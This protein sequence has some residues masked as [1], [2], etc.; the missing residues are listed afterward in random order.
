MNSVR[1]T[2]SELWKLTPHAFN[3]WR[4]QNDLPELLHVFKEKLPDFVMWLEEFGIEPVF[5][6]PSH[7]GRWLTGDISKKY[8]E[9]SHGGTNRCE[10]VDT[11]GCKE[12]FTL[13][14]S[15]AASVF[16]EFE[17]LPY[18][19]WA[20]NRFAMRDFMCVDSLNRG[21]S[22]T[23]KY[24]QSGKYEVE[25]GRV[26]GTKERIFDCFDL[27]KLGE[28]RV[29]GSLWLD[30]NLDF[31]D[32]DKVVFSGKAFMYNWLEVSLSSCREMVLESTWLGRVCFTECM[33]EKLSV[34]H[35]EIRK[36]NFANSNLPGLVLANSTLHNVTIGGT[37]LSD[38]DI[39][40]TNIIDLTYK[41][42]VDKNNSRE[43]TTIKDVHR[44]L[45]IAFQ[46]HGKILEARYHYY[47][48]RIFE[49]KELFSPYLRFHERFPR[50]GYGGSL[51]QLFRYWRTGTYTRSQV[52]NSII[53]IIR[54]H[55]IIWVHPKYFPIAAAYKIR[56]LSSMIQY[57]LWGYGERPLRSFYV[58]LIFV[59]LF[60]AAYHQLASGAPAG[61]F[62]D[63]LQFS[64]QMFLGGVFS[65]AGTSV[66]IKLISIVENIVGV[67]LM[68]LFVAGYANKARF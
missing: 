5:L 6:N 61:S 48:E 31:V 52:V 35:S 66:I 19:S 68:G 60:A 18:F 4:R 15:A 37:V 24:N 16:R 45:R 22:S 46:E 7:T 56:W 29:D 28:T 65:S 23:F 3:E 43:Y 1:M 2:P 13:D 50:S 39:F 54:F 27:L 9:Y 63:S 59:F 30:R 34:R 26:F 49:R 38:I 17:F 58:S 51:R 14:N 42:R 40:D 12:N 64:I 11:D 57:V 25:T 47:K 8:V 67:F 36:M 41:E 20:K 44:K 62:V 33:L 21:Y 53:D 55:T 10:I 32:L